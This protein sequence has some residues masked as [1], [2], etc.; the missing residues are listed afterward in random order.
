MN[1]GAAR[2]EPQQRTCEPVLGVRAPD[3][4]LASL[5]SLATLASLTIG[6]LGW[7][8]PM[9][10]LP[11]PAPALAAAP[12]TACLPCCPLF[13][14][15]LALP[16][17]PR[18]GADC[19]AL[20]GGF[21]PGWAPKAMP[22]EEGEGPLRGP[23]GALQAG[24]CSSDSDRKSVSVKCATRHSRAIACPPQT[25]V[26]NKVRS[27]VLLI[28]AEQF[29][30]AKPYARGRRVLVL[31]CCRPLARLIAHARLRAHWCAR[32]HHL[33]RAG[34]AHAG[35][36]LVQVDLQRARLGGHKR[37][38]QRAADLHQ[39]RA[40]AQ[41]A[42]RDAARRACARRNPKN[43]S[44]PLAHQLGRSGFQGLQGSQGASR[45]KAQVAWHTP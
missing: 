4:P 31:R 15:A 35:G 20:G 39:R 23:P 26:H 12:A 19:S 38:K 43:P 5:T 45:S 2:L 9:P 24:Y 34:P 18:P 29:T 44:D 8:R 14:P 30:R 16:S 6:S 13:A 17:S 37:H 33:T 36:H 28:P 1:Q 3:A 22:A 7:K 11:T 40:L 10:P 41:R 42:A 32:V 21:A 27:A 25:S